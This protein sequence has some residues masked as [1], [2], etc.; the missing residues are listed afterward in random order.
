MFYHAMER[1]HFA[2]GVDSDDGPAFNAF[3]SFAEEPGL[4]KGVAN[5]VEIASELEC[6]VSA[7][8]SAQLFVM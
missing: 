8:V 2:A 4:H 5:E 7:I 1:D 6:P 3:D